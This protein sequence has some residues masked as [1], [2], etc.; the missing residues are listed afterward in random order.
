MCLQYKSIENT[1]GKGEI[2]CNFVVW[3]RANLW[4]ANALNLDW[5]EILSF[6]KDL[7]FTTQ[8]WILTI[9]G[10]KPFENIM[11][12]GEM[13]VNSILSYSNNVFCSF[14]YNHHVMSYI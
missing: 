3:E 11:W 7:L 1:V 6:G 2:A 12:K 9:T 5:S 14:R 8:A 10:K 4:S 13:L